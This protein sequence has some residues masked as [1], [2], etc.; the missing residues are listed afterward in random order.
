MTLFDTLFGGEP[1]ASQ[2]TCLEGA[3]MSV[4]L[5]IYLSTYLSIYLAVYPSTK[6]LFA[7]LHTHVHMRIYCTYLYLRSCHAYKDS[8]N[9]YTCKY[10]HAC[11]HA[12]IHLTVS[13]CPCRYTRQQRLFKMQSKA[14]A[15]R[16][17]WFFLPVRGVRG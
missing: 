2:A 13:C 17:S 3:S 9:T 12:C 14:T 16:V 1:A 8:I 6:H 4:F 5:P 10:M 11:M 7:S 15:R